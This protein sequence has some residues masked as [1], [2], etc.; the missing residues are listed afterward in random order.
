MA[1]TDKQAIFVEHYL[2]SFNATEA[3]KQ[4]GYKGDRNA[5]ATIGH[6][7]LKKD[8]IAEAISLRIKEAAMGADEVM[9]RL[10]E[11]ARASYSQYIDEDG[12]VD[13]EKI[14]KDKKAHLIKS[15]KHTPYGKNV[16]FYDAQAA[17]QFVGKYHGLFVDR[18]EHTGKDGEP[19]EVNVT[20]SLRSRIDSVASRLRTGDTTATDS[21]DASG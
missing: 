10:A 3:A 8:E 11:Q 20:Q 21:T 4:A 16:E 6:A 1:L 18:T 15:I 7:N 5:L 9:M 19:I 12:K 17:L 14:I 2:T 13:F